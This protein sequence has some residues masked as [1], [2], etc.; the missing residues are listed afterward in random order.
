[1]FENMIEK[2]LKKD[3]RS[4]IANVREKRS[5]KMLYAR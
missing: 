3:K 1:M 2:A 4:T 5:T